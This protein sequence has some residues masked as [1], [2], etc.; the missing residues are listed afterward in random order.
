MENSSDIVNTAFENMPIVVPPEYLAMSYFKVKG[1]DLDD[2]KIRQLLEHYRMLPVVGDDK[3]ERFIAFIKLIWSIRPDDQ[4]SIEDWYHGQGPLP[5]VRP[6]DQFTIMALGRYGVLSGTLPLKRDEEDPSK[7]T[8]LEPDFFAN[9]RQYPRPGGAAN[10]THECRVCYIDRDLVSEYLPASKACCK[11]SLEVCWHCTEAFAKR[12]IERDI[13]HVHCCRCGKNFTDSEIKERVSDDV[14]QRQ[15]NPLYK[16][17]V[18]ADKFSR[19]QYLMAR[20]SIPDSHIMCLAPNCD[21][22]QSHEGEDPMMTCNACEFKT[23]V[24]HKRP[25]HEGMTCAEFDALPAEIERAEDE[26]KSV[27][28]AQGLSKVCPNCSQSVIK[29]DNDCDHMLCKCSKPRLEE[30]REFS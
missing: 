5:P 24:H 22:A 7:L 10:G 20:K 29:A 13:N 23:C 4:E 9:R 26:K 27:A 28:L 21:S 30:I 19:Y 18:A 16:A 3:S 8:G 17:C 1:G 2:S 15:V 14:Y 25:W 11:R 6:T 12:S